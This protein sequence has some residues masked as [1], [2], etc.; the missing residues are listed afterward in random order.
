MAT[1]EDFSFPT[2]TDT[3]PRFIESPRLWRTTSLVSPSHETPKGEDDAEGFKFL[4]YCTSND[5]KS[6]SA[7]Q[8]KSFSHI[9]CGMKTRRH[10]DGNF[11]SD[12]EDEDDQKEK[13]D[14]LWEDFNEEFSRN[15]KSSPSSMADSDHQHMSM[16]KMLNFGC[17]QPPLKLSRPNKKPSILEFMKVLKKRF[18]LQ[19]SHR[20]TKKTQR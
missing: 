18:L 3:P 7:F 14:M 9:E 8:R 13:M 19:N 16:M 12:H 2:T 6:K 11:G 17:V 15:S 20:S 4:C 10:E 1:E 5:K